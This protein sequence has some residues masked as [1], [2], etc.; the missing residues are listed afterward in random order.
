MI[1]FLLNN[2]IS[3]LIILT[4]IG[5]TL[6]LIANKQWDRLKSIAYSLMLTAERVLTE[7]VGKE[8]FDLVFNAFYNKY[9]PV[10]IKLF[11]SPEYIK[12][13]LQYWYDESKEWLK[14]DIEV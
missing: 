11:V 5:F 10:W 2:W 12:A 1:D 14:A 8:K 3:I 9:V 7:S 6:Y 4:F 13:V